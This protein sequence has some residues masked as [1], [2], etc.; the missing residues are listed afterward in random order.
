MTNIEILQL[1]ELDKPRPFRQLYKLRDT[2]LNSS[3]QSSMK[4]YLDARVMSH[5]FAASL[6]AIVATGED[7]CI[8]YYELYPL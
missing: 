1:Y 3:V 2:H 4:V 5:T 8:L 6:N 7:Q